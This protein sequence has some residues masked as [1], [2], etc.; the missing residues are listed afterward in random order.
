M[1]PR[2]RGPH[3]N[4]CG[5][6]EDPP[7]RRLLV[8]P[9][10]AV[11]LQLAVPPPRDPSGPAAAPDCD[12]ARLLSHTPPDHPC[13]HRVPAPRKSAQLRRKSPPQHQARKHPI[14]RML[15]ACCPRPG[16]V[17]ADKFAAQRHRPSGAKGC[18][19]NADDVPFGSSCG[20][21]GSMRR[22]SRRSLGTARRPDGNLDRARSA[23][24]RAAADRRWVRCPGQP[25]DRAR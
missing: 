2:G 7:A 12:V 11:S 18:L 4:C 8:I 13:P 6:S 22:A 3:S 1:W 5:A 14:R 25:A 19:Q 21:S 20:V 17:P 23:G 10:E 9:Q 24:R 16:A 15:A